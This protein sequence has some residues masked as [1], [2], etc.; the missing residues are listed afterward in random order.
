MT[1]PTKV[2]IAALRQT[3]ER[4]NREVWACTTDWSTMLKF[5]G[6][7]AAYMAS[8]ATSVAERIERDAQCIVL[9]ESL[10][11]DKGNGFSSVPYP[12]RAGPKACNA[13]P[14]YKRYHAAWLAS[15]KISTFI[16][17]GDDAQL[18]SAYSHMAVSWHHSDETCPPQLRQSFVAVALGLLLLLVYDKGPAPGIKTS[19]QQSASA[20]DVL[21][22][23]Q[24]VQP[25][26]YAPVATLLAIQIAAH[27]VHY[28]ADPRPEAS[29]LC[30]LSASS[31]AA[32]AVA[33]I[34][35]LFP[36]VNDVADINK[37]S[38][39]S[40]MSCDRRDM[41]TAQF[42]YSVNSPLPKRI[43]LTAA[44][45]LAYIVRAR[46]KLALAAKPIDVPSI[47]LVATLLHCADT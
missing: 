10:I 35:S 26:N 24:S 21:R 6:D 3:L 39:L 2:T 20:I 16:A 9:L 17:T 30:D 14:T 22:F 43:P 29:T 13:L 11:P 7:A 33:H 15:N 38:R 1:S 28:E 8:P 32:A 45:K 46:S 4:S 25:I 41:G 34:V 23:V 27:W 42:E 47:T 31:V 19:A 36:R 5:E 12:F 40:A 44:W 18:A 37:F